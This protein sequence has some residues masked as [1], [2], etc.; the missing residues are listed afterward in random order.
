MT[1]ASYDNK[2]TEREQPERTAIYLAVLLAALLVVDVG[3]EW[4]AEVRRAREE[5]TR[6][7]L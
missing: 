7:P 1:A 6:W 4:F 3:S 5:V 2:R